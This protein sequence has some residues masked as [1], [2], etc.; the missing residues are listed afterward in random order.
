MRRHGGTIYGLGLR[1]CGSPEDA[2]EMVQETF[3]QAF[4]HWRQFEGRSRPTTWLYTIARRVCQRQNRPR[5]GEPATLEP[6]D[7]LLP[8]RD[9][10]LADLDS[11]DLEATPFSARLRHE[12]AATIERALGELPLDFRMPLVL[13][14]IA[15]LSIAETA[16][17]LELPKNTVK[18]RVHRARL[19]LRKILDASLP[20]K[21]EPATQ[22]ATVCYT[23]LR[24]KLDALD[25]GVDL[26]YSDEALCARCRS[27]FATLDLGRDVCVAFGR[28]ELPVHVRA[29]VETALASAVTD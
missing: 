20:Q 5:A 28:G 11:S 9:G 13:V 15:E 27:V 12:A 6:L 4:R 17:V 23:M 18:T 14:D 16:T 26:P 25:R 21:D 8:G 1:L 7:E 24:A 10:Q 2:E 3:L 22:P 19:K 29:A